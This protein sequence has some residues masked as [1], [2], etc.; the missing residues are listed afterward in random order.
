[1]PQRSCRGQAAESAPTITTRGTCPLAD[2]AGSDDGVAE[3][4]G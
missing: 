3:A 4:N 2:A 1:M